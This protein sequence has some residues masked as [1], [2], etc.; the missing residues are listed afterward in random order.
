[1]RR[2]LSKK[3]INVGSSHYAHILANRIVGK[4]NGRMPPTL[5]DFADQLRQLEDR[6][7]QN[8]LLSVIKALA[9]K[10]KNGMSEPKEELKTF[11]SKLVIGNNTA[12]SPS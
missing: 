5:S 6:L 8:A 2:V 1:M 3:L 9:G 10:T 7:S 12:T 4:D 11:L